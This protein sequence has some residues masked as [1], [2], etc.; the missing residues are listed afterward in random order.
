ML[1][2]V[3]APAPAEPVVALVLI[4]VGWLVGLILGVTLSSS[5]LKRATDKFYTV[6]GRGQIAKEEETI[7]N[8]YINQL[9]IN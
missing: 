2:S 9:I 3:L 6:L 7:T 1:N 5:V 4:V 8:K